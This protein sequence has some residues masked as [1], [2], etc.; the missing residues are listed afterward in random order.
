VYLKQKKLHS[1]FIIHIRGPHAA[2]KDTLAGQ[3]N[4]ENSIASRGLIYK[5]EEKE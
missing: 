2:S 5:D 3:L 4:E 1:R